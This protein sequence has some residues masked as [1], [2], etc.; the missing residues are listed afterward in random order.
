MFRVYHFLIPLDLPF[1]P[2]SV[3][4]V[5][6]HPVLFPAF[7]GHGLNQPLFILLPPVPVEGLIPLAPGMAARRPL[8]AVH[9]W[10]FIHVDYLS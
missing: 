3:T 7:T 8:P 2:V 10:C 4:V 5:F 9:A 1:V 6:L